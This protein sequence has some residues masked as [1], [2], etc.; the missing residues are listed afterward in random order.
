MSKLLK[1]KSWL[2]P[3]EAAKYLTNVFSEQVTEADIYQLGLEGRLTL[4]VNLV[5]HASAKI[6]EVVPLAGCESAEIPAFHG[7]GTITFYPNA[8]KLSDGTA[9][10]F[11]PAV[12]TISGLWDL[13]MIGGECHVVSDRYHQLTGG[14]INEMISLEGAFVTDSAGKIAQLLKFSDG[15]KDRRESDNYYPAGEDLIDGAIVVR[16]ECLWDLEARVAEQAG[17]TKDKPMLAR[18]RAT[19]HRIIGAMLAELTSRVDPATKAPAN[20]RYKTQADLIAELM[21]LHPRKEGISRTTLEN[22]FAEAK[23]TLEGD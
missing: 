22:V 10:K 15:A 8:I 6:G 16:T 19:L 20:P 9:V 1:L 7:N 11:D 13:P 18:E 21:D 12:R 2:T 5:N 23:R 3:L 17:T 4:S 14:P